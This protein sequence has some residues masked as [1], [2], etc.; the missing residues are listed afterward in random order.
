LIPLPRIINILRYFAK[1]IT[2]KNN[3]FIKNVLIQ[4]AKDTLALYSGEKKLEDMT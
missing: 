4:D 1:R 2:I 3:D